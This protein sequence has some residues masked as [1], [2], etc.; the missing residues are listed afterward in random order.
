MTFLD[1]CCPPRKK[2][3]RKTR[4]PLMS[5]SNVSFHVKCFDNHLSIT[6]WQHPVC[7]LCLFLASAHVKVHTATRPP[8]WV[9]AACYNSLLLTWVMNLC[10][11]FTHPANTP[12]QIWCFQQPLT[13]QKQNTMSVLW[14]L[15]IQNHAD[16]PADLRVLD[17]PVNSAAKSYSKSYKG[18]LCNISPSL[19]FIVTPHH[20]Q[21]KWAHN[22]LKIGH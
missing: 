5:Q 9:A 12:V 14:H 13:Y 6:P 11:I 19:M 20:H 15:F 22:A 7:S 3:W 10:H 8:Q 4:F 16:P 18:D 2:T 21:S 1:L 17:Q